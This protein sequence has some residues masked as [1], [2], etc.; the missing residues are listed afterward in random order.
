MMHARYVLIRNNNAPDEKPKITWRLMKRVWSYAR[1]YRWWILGML[2]DDT[3]HHRTG[4]ADSA[5]PA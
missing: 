1:P 2:A 3:G 5:D 4:A